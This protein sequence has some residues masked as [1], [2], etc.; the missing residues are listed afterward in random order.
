VSIS[1][2]CLLTE[3]A[4]LNLLSLGAQSTRTPPEPV[5][6]KPIFGITYHR[7][8][9]QTEAIAVTIGEIPRSDTA[10]ALLLVGQNRALRGIQDP[11]PEGVPEI[12]AVNE[13]L[14]PAWFNVTLESLEGYQV[15]Q[16]D[17]EGVLT[18]RWRA[19]GP[20]GVTSVGVRDGSAE[21]VFV[22]DCDPELDT[23]KILTDLLRL[24]PATVIDSVR[25]RQAASFAQGE[26]A[27]AGLGDPGST[28]RPSLWYYRIRA[29]L[30][31]RL[32]VAVGVGKHLIDSEYPDELGIVTQRFPPLP[33][34]VQAW[35]TEA[36]LLRLR[37]P[38]PRDY[39]Q[40]YARDK[41]MLVRELIRR[42]ASNEDLFAV[43]FSDGVD[44]RD[45]ANA[46]LREI[47][48]DGDLPARLPLLTRILDVSRHG[49][50][51][52]VY[53]NCAVLVF[54]IAERAHLPMEPQALDYAKTAPEPRRAIWYLGRVSSSRETLEELSSIP[55]R[56]SDISAKQAAIQA[57]KARIE[58][59]SPRTRQRTTPAGRP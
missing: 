32:Y 45:V 43:G 55:V 23:K 4:V 3:L 44:G 5:T 28:Q 56:E 24:R 54:S 46:I 52:C 38:A 40:S 13:K 12:L 16:S 27:F 2:V 36:I 53:Y 8:P 9:G 21:S 33:K 30:D 29:I 57:I 10:E 50:S 48:K 6:P 34:V 18:A 26:M 37:Q 17:R 22:F 58:K 47:D 51:N 19:R 39:F 49:T 25:V 35:T 14:I 59:S 42:R 11:K 31:E 1:R 15:Q 20:A 7:P 41:T